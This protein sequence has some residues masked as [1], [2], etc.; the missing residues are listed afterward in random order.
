VTHNG[1]AVTEVDQ[2]LNSTY[3]RSYMGYRLAPDAGS[4]NVSVSWTNSGRGV[5]WAAVFVHVNQSDPVGTKA[6]G[7]G[8]EVTGIACNDDDCIVSHLV[9]MLSANPTKDADHTL[10][11]QDNA[12]GNYGN[13]SGSY[14][15]A[16]STSETVTWTG[17]VGVVRH[18]CLPLQSGLTPGMIALTAAF[19][20]AAIQT[21]DTRVK[22]RARSRRTLLTTKVRNEQ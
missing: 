13:A 9:G 4:N 5:I 15:L 10:I 6:E 16:G 20:T 2:E 14:A 12:A 8:M 11:E 3:Y 7:T 18:Y 1:K 19:H 17:S 21:Y 22:L